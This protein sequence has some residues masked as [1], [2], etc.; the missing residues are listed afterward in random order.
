MLGEMVGPA[1]ANLEVERGRIEEL[2]AADGVD[3]PVQPWD[4]AYYAERDKAATYDVDANAVKPYFELD[5]VL[6]DGI[7]HA[8]SLLYGVSLRAAHRPAG[9]RRRRPRLRGPR[10][11]RQHAR[12]VRLRLVRPAH[13][14][15]AAPGWTSSSASPTCSAPARSWWS[16]S[17]CRSR[18]PGSRR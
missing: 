16:A 11:R 1:M 2:L 4:W 8:A 3:G 5:R 9:L 10:R 17:T 12:A 7:F 13:Q 6:T 14:A 15:A 18:P